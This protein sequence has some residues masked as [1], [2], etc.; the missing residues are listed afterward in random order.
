VQTTKQ[1]L[2]FMT[3][4]ALA[5]FRRADGWEAGADAEVTFPGAGVNVGTDTTVRNAP[6]VGIVFGE[7]GLLAGA[8][9]QGSKYSR[10]NR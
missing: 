3:E 2:F 8:S 10:V 1:A 6:V 4:D 5:R 7:D 9:L